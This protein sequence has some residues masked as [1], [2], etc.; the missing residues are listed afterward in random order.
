[1]SLKDYLDQ[2]LK[3]LIKAKSMSFSNIEVGDVLGI[4][5][6]GNTGLLKGKYDW[7]VEV[8]EVNKNG[9][10]FVHVVED[11]ARNTY[12]SLLFEDTSYLKKSNYG[13]Q[14]SAVRLARK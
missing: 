3:E 8:K 14:W 4:H 11:L 12:T 7:T 5:I 2:T 13:R 10:G 6:E 1:M 9:I